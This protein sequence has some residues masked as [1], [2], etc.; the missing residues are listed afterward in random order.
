MFSLEITNVTVCS[1]LGRCDM[2]PVHCALNIDYGDDS[3][4]GSWN[5]FQMSN[6][7]YSLTFFVY[8]IC[9][10]DTVVIL[11]TRYMVYRSIEMFRLNW[12]E[13]KIATKMQFTDWNCLFFCSKIELRTP[14]Y[15]GRRMYTVHF[16][17]NQN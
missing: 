8:C 6:S 14:A 11:C 12:G 1:I 5:Q 17:S 13:L 15:I 16:F 2:K 10:D 9:I 4:I 7:P 3:S